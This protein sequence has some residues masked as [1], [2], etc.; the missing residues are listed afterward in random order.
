VPKHGLK[1]ILNN[2]SGKR[3]NYELVLEQL[4]EVFSFTKENIR[5]HNNFEYGFEGSGAFLYAQDPLNNLCVE[6]LE[7]LK[8][9]MPCQA[10]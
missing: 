10:D 9:I 5:T 7:K 6:N 8:R 4:H 1:L 3:I 2:N